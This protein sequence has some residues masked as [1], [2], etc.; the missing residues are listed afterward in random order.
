MGTK[1][2]FI[3]DV[4]T[5]VFFNTEHGE[6]TRAVLELPSGTIEYA[7]LRLDGNAWLRSGLSIEHR[8]VPIDERAP[9]HPAPA[10]APQPA[11]AATLGLAATALAVATFLP[12]VAAPSSPPLPWS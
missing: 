1:P 11:P 10:P 8:V 4:C 7:V 2:L 6:L 3:D 12:A 9:A 5:V